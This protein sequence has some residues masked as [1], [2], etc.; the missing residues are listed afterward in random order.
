MRDF[1]SDILG[2]AH[3]EP[4]G[5]LQV[6]ARAIVIFFASLVLVRF[7]E[8][9]FFAKKNAFDVVMALILASM[10]ARAINGKE[11]LLAT[12]VAGFALVLLHRLLS[13]LAGHSERFESLLKGHRNLMMRDGK[14]MR[15]EMKRHHVTENDL[16]EQLRL[17][18]VSHHQ[19]VK[20]AHLE[21]SGEISVIRMTGDAK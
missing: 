14:L 15:S 4:M 11:P 19:D 5:I 17:K 6:T 12:I 16:L 13:V 21:R 1:L 3:E 10:L 2:L 9:R 18:G 20:T 8:K 7:A